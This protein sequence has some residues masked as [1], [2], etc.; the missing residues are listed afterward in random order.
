RGRRRPLL[1]PAQNPA[2]ARPRCN[3]RAA[4]ME[5]CRCPPCS[6][7]CCGR[8]ASTTFHRCCPAITPDRKSTRLNSSHVAISYAAFCLKKK[9]RRSPE[10]IGQHQSPVCYSS[11]HPDHL[12]THPTTPKPE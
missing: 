5:R 3:C 12:R 11:E 4:A 7:R 6:T 8:R 1:A 2:L 10:Q 9:E